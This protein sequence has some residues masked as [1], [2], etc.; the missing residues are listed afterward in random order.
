MPAL[1]MSSG[2]ALTPYIDPGAD[3]TPCIRMVPLLPVGHPA[4]RCSSPLIPRVTPMMTG[5]SSRVD[6]GVIGV[7]DAAGGGPRAGRLAPGPG[8]DQL[9]GLLPVHPAG[10]TPSPEAGGGS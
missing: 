4:G 8:R 10:E 2:M 1:V 7:C 9:G 6:V 3:T 5:R